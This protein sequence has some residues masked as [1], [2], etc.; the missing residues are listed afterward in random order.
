VNEATLKSALVHLGR[1][2]LPGHVLLRHEDKMTAGI[3]D[4]SVTGHGRTL[5]IEVKFGVITGRGIQAMTMERLAQYGMAVYVVYALSGGVE[6]RTYDGVVL[7]KHGKL[8]QH[9]AVLDWIRSTLIAGKV[10]TP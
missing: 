8:G 2:T 10:V 9:S 7:A 1:Q 3:P 6:I 5:W 4:I